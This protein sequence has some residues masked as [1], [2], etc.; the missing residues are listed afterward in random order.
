MYSVIQE[1]KQRTPCNTNCQTCHSLNWKRWPKVTMAVL[2]QHVKSTQCLTDPKSLDV[3]SIFFSNNALTNALVLPTIQENW[4]V[5]KVI[6]IIMTNTTNSS[7]RLEETQEIIK[8]SAWETHKASI[9]WSETCYWC[10]PNP[11][12]RYTRI[13]IKEDLKLVPSVL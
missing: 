7:D 11:V 3:T 5:A 6:F 10:K 2:V 4:L 13:P 12:T 1:D 9:L 8:R